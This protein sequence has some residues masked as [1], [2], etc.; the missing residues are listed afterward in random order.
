VDN[1]FEKIQ[2]E[3]EKQQ[4]EQEKK[5]KE[6]KQKTAGHPEAKKSLLQI[7]AALDSYQKKFGHYPASGGPKGNLSWRVELLP[8]LGEGELYKQ[9]KQDEPWDGP[10]NKPLLAKMPKVFAPA[11]A[12]P[13]V[14]VPDYWTLY[15]VF[16]KPDGPFPLSGK[17]PTLKDIKDGPAKTFLVVESNDPFPWTKPAD[18]SYAD[19]E[20][21]PKLGHSVTT[22]FHAV[23]FDGKA[24]FI[25]HTAP[26]HNLRLWITADDGRDVPL[27]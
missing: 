7:G 20:E 24:H 18:I 19:K 2:K 11:R 27:P 1:V 13:D 21:V 6:N 5:N 10:T 9:F 14:P 22:G 25:L 26:E 17:G 23:T 12:D 16:T 3:Q 8:F 15:Q 4:K